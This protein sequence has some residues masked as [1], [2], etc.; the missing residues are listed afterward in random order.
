VER[1]VM[2]YF[3]FHEGRRKLGRSCIQGNYGYELLKIYKQD[4]A[5]IHEVLQVFK[6]EKN[7]FKTLPNTSSHHW[8][9]CTPKANRKIL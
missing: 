8:K 9:N 1:P 6:E 5:V 3:T 7:F 2:L 4:P